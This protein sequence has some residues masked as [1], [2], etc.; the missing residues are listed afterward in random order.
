MSRLVVD[1]WS[2]IEYLRGGKLGVKVRTAMERSD[3]V[4]THMVTIAEIV[5]KFERERLDSDGAWRA[6][7]ALSKIFLPD[8]IDAKHVGVLHASMKLRSPNFSLADAFVLQAAKK[9][10]ARILT[11]DPDFR[12]VDGAVM[13]K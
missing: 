3:E 7:T 12:R 13:V 6:V 10:R 5:S 8:A 9:L 11:G 4:L 1:S 2:W